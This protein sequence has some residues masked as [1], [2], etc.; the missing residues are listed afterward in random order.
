V[1]G[2]IYFDDIIVVP[3]G[4]RLGPTQ[5]PTTLREQSFHAAEGWTIQE[6]LPGTFTLQR[7]GMSGPVTVGGY[8]FTYTKLPPPVIEEPKPLAKGKKR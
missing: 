5:A 3:E 4:Q 2:S 6:T 1:I 7:E 8:G